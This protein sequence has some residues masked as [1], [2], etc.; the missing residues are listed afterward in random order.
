MRYSEFSEGILEPDQE[1]MSGLMSAVNDVAVEYEKFLENNNDQDDPEE[2]AHLLNVFFEEDG[3]P[4]EVYVGATGQKAN[5]WYIQAGQVHGDGSMDLVLDPDSID[6]HWG[7]ETFKRVMQKTFEHENI[8]L[9]QRDRMGLSNYM[10]LPSGYQKGQKLMQKTGKERDAMRLYFR[11]PQELMAHGHDLYREIQNSSNP[12]KALRNP[13]S[14]RDEL[15][16]YDKY[17]QIFPPNAKP[18]QRMI[19][20]TYKYFQK[21][22]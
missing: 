13:E 9:M 18:L 3:I 15:P 5:D 16:T 17:R 12:K 21:N 1:F 11:D 2:L 8:H 4:I 20:Y 19:T 7:P 10:N 22:A 6:G 14:F